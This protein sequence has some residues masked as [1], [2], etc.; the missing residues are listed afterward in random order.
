MDLLR[1]R[2][3]C[4][5][6]QSAGMQRRHDLELRWKKNMIGAQMEY[7]ES[8]QLPSTV[9]VFCMRLRAK[10]RVWRGGTSAK[11]ADRRSKKMN[12]PCFC[13]S[14]RGAA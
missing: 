5:R 7:G 4:R 2:R 14:T 6:A 13:S 9:K 3:I 11:M 12:G 8:H 1:K 10:R